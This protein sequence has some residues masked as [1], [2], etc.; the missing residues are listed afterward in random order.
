MSDFCDILVIAVE[1]KDHDFPHT[2]TVDVKDYYLPQPRT[3]TYLFAIPRDF[4]PMLK[5]SKD[6]ISG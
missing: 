4:R 1:A 3:R 5:A 6:S 2:L